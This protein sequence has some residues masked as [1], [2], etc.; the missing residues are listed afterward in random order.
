MSIKTKTKM[1]DVCINSVQ[2]IVKTVEEAIE[3]SRT[4][5]KFDEKVIPLRDTILEKIECVETL[6]L[7]ILELLKEDDDFDIEV[8]CNVGIIQPF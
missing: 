2:N 1:R 5:N 3:A 4:E 7:E 8:T 6:I